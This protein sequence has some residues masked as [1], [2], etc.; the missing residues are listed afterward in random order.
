VAD[1]NATETAQPAAPSGPPLTQGARDGFRIAVQAC[2]NVGAL[3]TEALG[4]TV[5]VA[6]D[7]ARDGRPEQGTCVFW[8][9]PAAPRPPR[10]RPT[11][12]PAARSS[13]VA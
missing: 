6:F 8:N 3:S 12:P 10:N 7:M 9:S 5:V 2:W 13:A 4:T 1:A 11:R